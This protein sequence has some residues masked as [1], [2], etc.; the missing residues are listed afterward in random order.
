ME[1][2]DSEG[3]GPAFL[4]GDRVYVGPVNREATVIRQ[5]QNQQL[6]IFARLLISLESL[7]L[8]LDINLISY[9]QE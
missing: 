2:L 9:T 4:P 5:V 1:Q 8:T 3:N 7:L 6:T